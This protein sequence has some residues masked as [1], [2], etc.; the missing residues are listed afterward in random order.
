[1]HRFLPVFMVGLLALFHTASAD[2]HDRF[3][4]R[5]E[6]RRDFGRHDERDRREH[7]RWEHDRDRGYYDRDRRSGYYAPPPVYYPEPR[8]YYAPPPV[9]APPGV[10]LFFPFR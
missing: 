2:E 3:E 4:R 7:D 10:G 5:E 8:R 9:Y 1:M 6:G